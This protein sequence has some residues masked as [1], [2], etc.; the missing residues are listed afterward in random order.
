MKF[1]GAVGK[2]LL[3]ASESTCPVCNS[4]TIF[5]DIGM[6]KEMWELSSERIFGQNLGDLFGNDI[7][8][9]VNMAKVVPYTLLPRRS[10]IC[11]C[12]KAHPMGALP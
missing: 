10:V 8:L 12:I 11:R 5:E 1:P 6:C 9:G 7:R 3:V 2:N 4:V